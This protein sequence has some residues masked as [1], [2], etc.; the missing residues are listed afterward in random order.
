MANPRASGRGAAMR[1]VLTI[2]ILW[3]LLATVLPSAMA[4]GVGSVTHVSGVLSVKRADGANKILSVRSDVMEGDTLATQQD[5][6]A[7]VKFSD[8][9]EVVLRPGSQLKI[10]AYAFAESKPAS[11]NVV[12]SLLKGGLRAITGLV[13]KRSR[14]N[15][16]YKTPTATIGIRGTHFGLL[17]CND[18]CAGVPSV[19]GETPKNGLHIDVSSGSIGVINAG[20]QT[21]LNSGQFGFVGS[22]TTAPIAVPPEQGVQV[23]MPPSIRDNEAGGRSVGGAGQTECTL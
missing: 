10:D 17:F 5:T 4:A 11:D 15:V 18:D 14:D 6:Y 7:R 12:L 8:G 20:G 23:T 22:A 21:I 9:G 19:S 3:G 2:I 13:G 1:N 16:A